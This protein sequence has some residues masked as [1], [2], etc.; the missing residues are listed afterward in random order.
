MLPSRL[1]TSGMCIEVAEP[2]LACG[3]TSGS[4]GRPADAAALN[5][6]ELVPVAAKAEVVAELG[7]VCPTSDVLTSRACGRVGHA[8]I[9]AR[10]V[11]RC[12]SDPGMEIH[13]PEVCAHARPT[14]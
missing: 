14:L 10:V 4:G 2:L 9:C 6:L 3:L 11:M 13:V 7:A 8:H 1:S 12:W 5:A